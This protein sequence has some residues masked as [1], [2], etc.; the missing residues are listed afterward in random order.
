[1]ELTFRTEI[2]AED[3]RLVQN[4][5]RSTGFFREDEIEV[6]VELVE[7]AFSKGQDQS[8]YHF[9]FPECDGITCGFVCFGPTPCTLGTYDLYWIVVDDA[10]RGKGI[11]KKLLHETEYAL[12]LISARKLY[13]ETSSTAKYEPTRRFYLSCGYVEEARLK[14]FYNI[15]DDKVIYSKKL[16][17]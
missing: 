9:I 16:S 6:A 8:G 11:G 3:L 14:D 17:S 15:G 4:I 10:Y 13:I 7:E 2:N 12:H 5:A 1:M